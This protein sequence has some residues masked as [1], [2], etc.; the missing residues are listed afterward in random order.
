MKKTFLTK[1]ILVVFSVAIFASCEVAEK[2][3]SKSTSEEAVTTD[4]DTLEQQSVIAS[5]LTIVDYKPRKTFPEAGFEQLTP[6]HKAFLQ[7]GE[8]K[9]S[10]NTEKFPF[11]DGHSVRLAI[12]NGT[13]KF[14]FD[15]NK[16]IT[17]PKGVFLCAAYLCDGRGVSLKNAHSTQLTQLNIGVDEKK[18]IDLK[19]PMIFLNLPIERETA[20]ILVDFMLMNIDLSK[21][22][23]K[24]RLSI[25][26]QT[27][28]YLDSW[29]TLEI[30]GLAK[31]K[32]KILVELVN[33]KNL[34][35]EGV[36][37]HDE[38]EFEIQ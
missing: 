30:K 10:F 35:Y 19:Q 8:I 29:R 9:F 38:R 32:H 14:V 13:D 24:V 16:K 3:E 1:S 7:P 6:K 25:D 18:E 37:T 33:D 34:L 23:N 17:L 11:V 4:S 15:A 12:E 27:E 2:T 26:D 28:M 31:G 20:N 22:G 5:G 21:K 36:Y